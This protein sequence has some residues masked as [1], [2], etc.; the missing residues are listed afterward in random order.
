LKILGGVNISRLP[1]QILLLLLQSR[2]IIL[3]LT[4]GN[5]D[6]GLKIGRVDLEKQISLSQLL[7]ITD[8]NAN[9]RTRYPGSDTDDVRSDLA[10]PRPGML[11][12]SV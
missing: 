2:F 5:V 9:D 3:N 7:V 4:R 6:L 8:R 10:I 1:L 12:V 11:N